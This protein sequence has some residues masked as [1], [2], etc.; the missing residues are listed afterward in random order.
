MV[1]AR[2][3]TPSTSSTLA[4]STAVSSNRPL[5]E[6][7]CTCARR[8]TGR[9]TPST[10]RTA[11]PL[12]TS[13]VRFHDLRHTAASLWANAG[14]SI[15]IFKASLWLGHE[16]IDTTVRLYARLFKTDL[17]RE[18]DDYTAFLARQRQ[19]AGANPAKVTPLRR[20]DDTA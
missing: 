10:R 11:T 6:P 13:A 5:P 12:L 14:G 4:R 16:S 1:G 19:A 9:A 8:W 18:S 3:S 7:G 17:S 15:D 20:A 2:R